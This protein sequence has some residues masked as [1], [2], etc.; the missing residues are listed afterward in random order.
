MKKCLG[1]F[2][3]EVQNLLKTGDKGESGDQASMAVSLSAQE[4]Y[5]GDYAHDVYIALWQS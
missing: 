1:Q 2:N 5:R 4:L 3:F